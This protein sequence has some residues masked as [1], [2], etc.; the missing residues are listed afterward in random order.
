MWDWNDQE[1]KEMMNIRDQAAA[2]LIK[3]DY[4]SKKMFK[5][6]T[7]LLNEFRKKQAASK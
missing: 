6:T 2:E 7:T 3:S 1:K 4:I 5:R